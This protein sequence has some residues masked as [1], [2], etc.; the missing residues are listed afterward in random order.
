VRK[1]LPKNGCTFFIST[2]TYPKILI[3]YSAMPYIQAAVGGAFD[4]NSITPIGYCDK[5][6]PVAVGI[7]LFAGVETNRCLFPKRILT[8]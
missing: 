3:E 8:V 1:G 7:I 5:P 4:S 6:Q 2:V